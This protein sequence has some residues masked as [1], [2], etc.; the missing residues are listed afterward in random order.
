MFNNV[1]L[2]NDGTYQKSLVNCSPFEINF[3]GQKTLYAMISP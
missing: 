1:I 3:V 2:N